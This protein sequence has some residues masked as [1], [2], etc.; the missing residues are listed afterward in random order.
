MPKVRRRL[1]RSGRRPDTLA[2]LWLALALS[3]CGTAPPRSVSQVSLLETAP[4]AVDPEAALGGLTTREPRRVLWIVQER[5]QYDPNLLARDLQ[6]IERY[7]RAHGYY[8]AKVVAAR[9]HVRPLG[10]LA[11][12]IHV[13]PGER[14]LVRSIKQDVRLLS[15]PGGMAL[16]VTEVVR[17]RPG[18]P[19][20][21]DELDRMKLDVERTLQEAGYAYARVQA[22]ATIDLNAR[23]AD[24]QV[25]VDPGQA[26]RFGRIQISGLSHIPRDKVESA[27]AIQPGTPYSLSAL[28]DARD[29]LEDLR[30]FSRIDIATDL[31]S[32]EQPDVPVTVVVEEDKLR[33]LTLGGGATL[34]VLRLA[35]HLRTGWEHKNFLGGARRFS[36]QAKPG[37]DLF[38][39]RLE[40][41][42]NIAAPTRPLL[43]N[44]VRVN[45][46]QPALFGGR[47]RGFMRA[48]Y[49]IYP[50]L[51]SLPEDA[52]PEDE[53]IVGYHTVAA[54]LGLE[55]K[56]LRQRIELSPSYNWRANFPFTYQGEKPAGLNKVIVSYPRLSAVFETKPGDLFDGDEDD[57]KRNITL[58]FSNSIELAGLR[59]GEHHLFGGSL[60][61]FKLEPELR[62]FVPLTRKRVLTLGLRVKFG[63]LLLPDY[64]ETL[65]DPSADPTDPNVIADQQKLLFRAFYSGGPNSNRGYALRAIS[66]HGPVGFLIPTGL[67]CSVTPLPQGCIR[68]LGGFSLWEASLELR[69]LASYPLTL[70]AFADASDVTRQVAG[71]QLRHPHLSVGPGLRYDT[72]VGPLR[73]DFGVRVPGLQSIGNSQLPIEHGQ[74]RPTLFGAPAAINVTIGEAF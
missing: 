45:L 8:D 7:Y 53:I 19:F 30:V 46:A 66:P 37:I 47:T 11:I 36:I 31:S 34:D 74:E 44:D 58:R 33:L 17:L 12:E 21:E 29:A 6:R 28:E 73:L 52:V 51:Y 26:A 57:E 60:S 16:R 5:D 18:Q 3:G 13:A 49:E 71:I 69:W 63:F 39:T 1:D 24:I 10:D 9:V 72:P 23:A 62:G 43:R 48:S 4:S 38:P 61:D 35:F 40:S 54:E 15:L 64:G 20:V 50:L 22:R 55:R 2:G 56:Y 14:V 68:P 25:E 27:L 70:V 65:R 41:F 67:N 42:D 32:P 59:A